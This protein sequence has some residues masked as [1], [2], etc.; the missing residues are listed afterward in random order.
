MSKITSY[1]ITSNTCK[2][3][4]NEDFSPYSSQL[5]ALSNAV[6]KKPNVTASGKK[7][8]FFFKQPM[9]MIRQRLKLVNREIDRLQEEA[10]LLNPFTGVSRYFM[11]LAQLERLQEE[12]DYLC[13]QASIWQQEVTSCN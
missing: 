7:L 9:E 12:R 13:D 2:T 6:T 10:Q 5:Q 3:H 4:K 11:N 1:M 8:L